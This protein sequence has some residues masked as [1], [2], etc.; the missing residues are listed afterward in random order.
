MWSKVRNAAAAQPNPV[1]A[2][3]VSGMNDVLNT[4][5][6][7]QAAW[8]NR[9]P[10]AAWGLMASISIGCSMLIG[11]S[12]RHPRRLVFLIVPLAVSISFLLIADIDSPTGGLIRVNPQNLDSLSQ[13]IRP[14]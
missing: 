3:V 1:M 7:T 10:I 12:V 8:W 6:Y 4:Q 13:S 2:V 5:G 14:Q 9:I 11:F